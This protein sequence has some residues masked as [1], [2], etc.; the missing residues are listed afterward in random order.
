MTSKASHFM[1]NKSSISHLDELMDE[2][3][4]GCMV[5]MLSEIKLRGTSQKRREL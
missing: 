1:S 3:S 2:I 4:Y 5:V